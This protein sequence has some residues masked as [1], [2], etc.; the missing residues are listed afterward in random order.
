MSGFASH[1]PGFPAVFEAAFARLQFRVEEAYFGPEAWTDRVAA[2]LYAG[3][4]FAAENPATSNVLTNEALA[5]GSDGIARYERLL[6]FGADLLVPGRRE[7]PPDAD[8]PRFLELAL[9]GAVTSLVARHLGE[10]RA[11][12][13][14]QLTPDVIQ[15]VLSPYLGAAQARRVAATQ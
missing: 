1:P 12:E 6:G 10:D 11:E 7:C 13:L 8:L 4:D 5:H 14:P 2:A 3:F 9:S 15:F